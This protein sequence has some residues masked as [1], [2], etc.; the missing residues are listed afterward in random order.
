MMTPNP[1]SPVRLENPFAYVVCYELT[2]APTDYIELAQ[3]LQRS[4]RWMHYFESLWFILRYEPLVELSKLLQ[5]KVYGSDKILV[6]PAVG[7]TGGLL[8]K[9][10]WDWLNCNVPKLW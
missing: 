6:F 4:V 7:P 8:P 1:S 3:E 5:S 9:D 2:H 10:A